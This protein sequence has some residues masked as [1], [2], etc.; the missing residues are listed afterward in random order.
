[1]LKVEAVSKCAFDDLNVSFFQV[2]GPYETNMMLQWSKAVSTT[3]FF[4]KYGL[5][6]CRIQYVIIQYEI[7]SHSV[8]QSVTQLVIHSVS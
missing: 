1:M 8:L 3:K 5:E 2:Y 7:T 4:M 6:V